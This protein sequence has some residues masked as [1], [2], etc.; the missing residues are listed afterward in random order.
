M[1]RC[2]NALS[3]LLLIFLILT[4]PPYAFAFGPTQWEWRSSAT[5]NTVFPT[6]AAALAAT[7]ACAAPPFLRD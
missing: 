7:K 2:K 4:I 5:G 6:Q 1:E 3:S